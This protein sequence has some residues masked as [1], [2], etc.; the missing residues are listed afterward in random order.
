[1]VTET[2]C[3]GFTP[4]RLQQVVDDAYNIFKNNTDGHNADYIPYLATV[5]SSLFGVAIVTAAGY[6]EREDVTFMSSLWP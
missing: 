4:E 2:L 3:K 5:N 6:D 1:M